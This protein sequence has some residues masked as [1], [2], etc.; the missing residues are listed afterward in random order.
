MSER[1]D[2][3]LIAD[4]IPPR[5]RVLDLG[6][7]AGDLLQLLTDQG[8]SGTGVEIEPELLVQGL[9]RGL[10]VIDLDLNTQLT[11]FADDSYD[12]VVVSRTLLNVQRPREVLKE[13]SR[14]A[15]RCIVLVP[16]F[17]HWHNRLRLLRGRMPMSSDLPFAWYDTPNLHFT[18]LRDLEPLFADLGMVVERRLAL[19]AHGHPDRLAALR[20]NLLASSAVYLLRAR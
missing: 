18:S 15:N 7:G 17:A 9:R 4:L 12:V 20:P 16:N 19:D 10:N 14:I 6:C 13:S 8:C 2:L 5:S 3:A 1:A 11:E